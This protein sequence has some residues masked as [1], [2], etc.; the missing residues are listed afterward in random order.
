MVAS[1]EE[2]AAEHRGEH[3]SPFIRWSHVIG[4]YLNVVAVAAMLSGR[5]RSASTS[6]AASFVTLTVG[7]LFEGNLFW[8]W[9]YVARHPMADFAVANATIMGLFRP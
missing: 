7:H 3:L 6:A 8:S 5:R 4:Q 1:Y 9:R 2:F